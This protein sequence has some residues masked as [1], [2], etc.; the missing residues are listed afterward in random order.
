MAK[1]D[2]PSYLKTPG[3]KMGDAVFYSV[4]KRS[5]M[6]TYVIP[7]NPRT[8]AQQKNRSLFAEAMASWKALPHEEKYLYKV[9][10]RNL[11]M[12]PHNL[13]VREYMAFHSEKDC[14]ESDSSVLRT[15][16]FIKQKGGVNSVSFNSPIILRCLSEA[17][18]LNL[19]KSSCSPPLMLKTGPG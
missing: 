3:G 8:E 1:I 17:S 13:Y 5:F 16:K 2:T 19:Q 18:P 4:G 6:R 15:D 10:T 9:R 11:D 14:T 12:H 7:R